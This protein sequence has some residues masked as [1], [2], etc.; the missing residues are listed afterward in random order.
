MVQEKSVLGQKQADRVNNIDISVVIPVYNAQS[1]LC[2]LYT[3]LKKTL[4]AMGITWQIIMV[5]DNSGDQ[6]WTL[7]KDLCRSDARVAGARLAANFGQHA[8]TV[9]GISISRGSYV[10][11]IDDDLDS[12][13]DAIPIL[14]E[15][16]TIFDVA[17]AVPSTHKQL[18]W[19]DS[20]STLIHFL[21][22]HLFK[23]Q[24]N[25]F[26]FGSFRLLSPAVV[27]HL[28]NVNTGGIYLNAEIL[29]AASCSGYVIAK[30]TKTKKPTR[31]TL[32]K[33]IKLA[34][35]LIWGYTSWPGWIA[36]LALI[37]ITAVI[38]VYVAANVSWHY[39]IICLWIMLTIAIISVLAVGLFYSR[40]R[41]RK[42]Y[43]IRES[44]GDCFI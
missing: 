26:P 24:D 7:I 34:A 40:L 41:K 28:R 31:Y 37:I 11:T 42:L 35:N 8:A 22:R 36:G 18:W 16:R 33:S 29:R 4:N 44:A 6:S 27:R 19:K 14:W 1:T 32:T 23:I 10:V 15:Q 25:R 13:P 20:G 2:E 38:P 17:F 30:D 5:D 39:Y 12:D 21:L 9:C 3:G 43:V